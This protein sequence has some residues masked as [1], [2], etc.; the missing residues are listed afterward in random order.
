MISKSQLIEKLGKEGFDLGKNPETTLR[1]YRHLGLIG[2]ST[3]R[4]EGPGRVQAF[5][6][7]I[8]LLKICQIRKLQRMGCS[9]N[10]IREIFLVEKGKKVLATTPDKDGKVM[11]ELSKSRKEDLLSEGLI[12]KVAEGQRVLQESE[13]SW[14][15][16][17]GIGRGLNIA[18]EL[19]LLALGITDRSFEVTGIVP[20]KDKNGHLRALTLKLRSFKCQR[21]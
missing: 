3:L 9:L 18:K 17:L 14:K 2:R 8:I 11:E 12:E 1:Y 16:H 21:K 13:E 15:H 20:V 10:E 6:S 5:Y 7:D 4:S 19:M